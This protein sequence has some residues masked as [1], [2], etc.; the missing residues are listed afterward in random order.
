MLNFV[1]RRFN[2]EKTNKYKLSIQ[3][4]LDGFLFCL[5]D[6]K[7]ECFV[8][9][10]LPISEN[11]GLEEI[12]ASEPL[13]SKNYA[14]AKCIIVNQKSTLVPTN[15]FD[16]NKPYEYLKFVC[17]INE[18]KILITQKIKEINAFCIFAVE[19][20]IFELVKK[21]QPKVEFY[22]Q[23]IPL[24]CTALKK[25]GKNISAF[26]SKKSIDI[27]ASDNDKLLLHNSYTTESLGD[28][29][30][31][32]AAVKDLLKINPDNI[33]LSGKISK[34]EEEEFADFFEN[35]K[36]EVNKT[37]MFAVGIENATLLLL[38]EKLDKCV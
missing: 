2:S 34:T 32:T 35:L 38:L 5:F 10:K 36:I 4:S 24:I 9:K 23:S 28:A 7:N 33:F 6:S 31:F 27:V 21:H 18:E 8:A 37:M 30:Y 25:K 26:V 29:I 17:D 15:L 1:H 20:F 16:K 13:L 3:I 14:S 22:H 19:K 11:F 12:F